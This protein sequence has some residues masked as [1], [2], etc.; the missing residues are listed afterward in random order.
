MTSVDQQSAATLEISRNIN[1]AAT[2]SRDVSTR[3]SKVNEATERAG[4]GASDVLSAANEL[5]ARGEDLKKQIDLF[6]NRLQ[7]G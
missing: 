1:E 4:D 2:G 6:T 5:A 7:Q 3:I